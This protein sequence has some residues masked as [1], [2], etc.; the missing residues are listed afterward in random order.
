MIVRS[1]PALEFSQ[2]DDQFK[3]HADGLIVAGP[4]CL[5][6][7]CLWECKGLGSQG[8]D[9]ARQGRLGAG[10]SCLRRPGG[11]LSGLSGSNHQSGPVHRG[12]HGQDGGA[13][14]CRAVRPSTGTGRLRPR[15]ADRERGRGRRDAAAR[16]RRARQLALQAVPSQREVLGRRIIDAR[17]T[18]SGSE[19]LEE[20]AGGELHCREAAG[21]DAMKSRRLLFQNYDRY[22][23]GLMAF[24]SGQQ[25]YGQRLQLSAAI[26]DL[27]ALGRPLEQLQPLR[28][29]IRMLEDVASGRALPRC[30][31]SPRQPELRSRPQQSSAE[32]NVKAHLVGLL[33]M[34]RRMG[35]A[36]E[37]A[38]RAV[39]SA[40]DFSCLLDRR[41][42]TP[43]KALLG[44]EKSL[45]R[46]DGR[47]A[48]RDGSHR[49]LWR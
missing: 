15:R 39:A 8:L 35:E 32:W 16:R 17:G 38:A 24:Q 47:A 25:L 48:P 23:L 7:P 31:T 42:T 21:E 4:D 19:R 37:E 33:Q 12:R 27:T 14:S 44:W 22:A 29:L 28:E 2:L 10:L 9:Q 36:P 18:T 13:A 20:V 43:G 41:A 34:R 26:D 3:G 46:T 40:C 5:L 30:A 11:A 45:R 49:P 1:G 6:Y